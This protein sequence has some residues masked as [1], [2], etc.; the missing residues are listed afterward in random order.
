MA[1]SDRNAAKNVYNQCN[2]WW[3]SGI[4]GPMTRKSRCANVYAK[5]CG[6]GASAALTRPASPTT[7]QE[8][9]TSTLAPLSD[10]CIFHSGHPVCCEGQRRPPC[11]TQSLSSRRR[12]HWLE[13]GFP[14][15]SSA[16]SLRTTF[17]K[18]ASRTVSKPL[19]HQTKHLWLYD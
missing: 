3:S 7:S 13:S 12:G 16:S 14:P 1:T 15:I 19:L 10:L 17:C 8:S 4:V 18:P 9:S 2:S 5:T 11:S 6:F